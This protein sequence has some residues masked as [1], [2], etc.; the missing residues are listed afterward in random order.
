M[1][2]TLRVAGAGMAVLAAGVVA[3]ACSSSPAASRSTTS[4]STSVPHRHHK[5]HPASPS[6]TTT[7][8]TTTTTS[9]TVPTIATC[10]VPGLSIATSGTGGAAGTEELTF[11]LTNRGTTPCKTY[12]YP[13]MLLLSTSGAPEP[14]TVDRGGAQ[15]FEKIPPSQVLLQPGATA[16]FNVGFEVVPVGTTSCSSAHEVEVTPPTNRTHATVSVGLGIEACDNGTLH[17]SPVFASTDTSATQTTA[18]P[19][20]AG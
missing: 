2:V 6:S 19:Q 5:S 13:G 15:S 7:S 20:P 9:S 8:S 18:P 16:Y 11:S 10:Q 14:T 12:G 1:R 3:S 4:T 17:V